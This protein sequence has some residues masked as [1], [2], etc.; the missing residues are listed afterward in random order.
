MMSENILEQAFEFLDNDNVDEAQKLF[1]KILESDETNGDAAFG[2]FLCI[3]DI[4]NADFD[5]MV[6]LLQ[7]V[8]ESDSE[9][10]PQAQKF[11]N[12]LIP[13]DDL[14]LYNKLDALVNKADEFD[15]IYDALQNSSGKLQDRLIENRANEMLDEMQNIADSFNDDDVYKMQNAA[16]DE[17]DE[18]EF[19]DDI[20]IEYKIAKT[21]DEV[22]QSY[23]DGELNSAEAFDLFLRVAEMGNAEAM[24]TVAF[25]Y[26]V[27]DGVE[28]DIYESMYWY[29][30]AAELEFSDAMC[31]LGFLHIYGHG[32]PENYQKGLKWIRKAVA[33]EN[34][35]AMYILAECYMNGWDVEE[36]HKTAFE[37][38]EQAANLGNQSAMMILGIMTL[39]ED[40]EHFDRERSQK[41]FQKSVEDVSDSQ[42]RCYPVGHEILEYYR[43]RRQF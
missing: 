29:R 42:K 39:N 37:Y 21:L 40:D 2:L 20:P 25:M 3:G 12:E 23:L 28:K 35:Q 32:I 10:K 9:F 31:N 22:Q 17:D 8:L 36:N 14:D 43:G 38:Y 30:R 33:L 6:H 1:E 26:S 24:T 11:L 13:P 7:I 41:F 34:N 18:D 15:E 27:G 16:L 4:K 19:S 5:E